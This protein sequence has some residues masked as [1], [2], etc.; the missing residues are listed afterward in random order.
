MKGRNSLS[1]SARLKPGLVTIASSFARTAAAAGALL[2]ACPCRT[3]ID[4]I[5][6]LT[7][8]QPQFTPLDLCPRE[9]A[10]TLC[11]KPGGQVSVS[12]TET[13]EDQ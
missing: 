3:M 6:L 5:A 12:P 2:L 13:E 1:L 11:E 8:Q 10:A 9:G 4:F 7:A